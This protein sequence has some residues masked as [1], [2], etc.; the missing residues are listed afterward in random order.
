MPVLHKL[1]IYTIECIPTGKKYVG[2]AAFFTQRVSRHK[3]DLRKNVHGNP[4]LQSAWNKYGESAFAFSEVECVLRKEDLVREEQ[5]WID[6]LHPDFNICKI[7]SSSLGVRHSQEVKA[8]RSKILKEYWSTHKRC[9]VSEETRA[10][11]SQAGS[12][13]KRVF[14]EE[15]KAKLSASSMNRRL[16]EEVRLK[17]STAN[18][19]KTRRFSEQHKAGIKAAWDK[20]KNNGILQSATN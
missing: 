11:M 10:K 20:R 4:H 9:P 12:G 17:I 18:R 3:N 7:A 2:S 1:R 15:H 8:A 16:P 13:R 6:L 5:G 19:G 14:S